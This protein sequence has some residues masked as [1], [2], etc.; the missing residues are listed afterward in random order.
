MGDGLLT[1]NVSLMIYIILFFGILVIVLIK[2]LGK[3]PSEVEEVSSEPTIDLVIRA[4][5]KDQC[6]DYFLLNP[7][8]LTLTLNYTYFG[9]KPGNAINGGKIIGFNISEL[10]GNFDVK[11]DDDG[12]FYSPFK[13]VHLKD[14]REKLEQTE[15]LVCKQFSEKTFFDKYLSTQISIIN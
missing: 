9:Q 8:G 2:V 5:G 11:A 14:N 13:T 3:K 6:K 4:N 15:I 12:F 1:I 10:G 7:E